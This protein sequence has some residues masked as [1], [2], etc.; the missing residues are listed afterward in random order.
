MNNHQNKLYPIIITKIYYNVF[1]KETLPNEL[2]TWN[3]KSANGSETAPGIYI[4][5]I[6]VDGNLY[7]K[8]LI[9]R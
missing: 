4:A 9:K 1:V 8:K 3:G 5:I 2:Y 7:K 6:E